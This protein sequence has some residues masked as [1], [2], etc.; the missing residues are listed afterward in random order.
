MSIQDATDEAVGQS[1]SWCYCRNNESIDDMIGCDNTTCPI[2]GF[3]CHA[4]I[5][6]YLEQVPK[7]KWLCPQC[8]CEKASLKEVNIILNCEL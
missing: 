1:D 5:L 8:R 3:I 6:L 7:G 2:H 4:C